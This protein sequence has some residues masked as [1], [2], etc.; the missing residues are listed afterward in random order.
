MST[1][2]PGLDDE[3]PRARTGSEN[4][5]QALA[6]GRY[7]RVHKLLLRMHPAKVAA[8]LEQAGREQR[9]AAWQQVD[10]AMEDR[11]LSHLRPALR[12]ELA[13]D[14]DDAPPL[15]PGEGAAPNQLESVCDALAAG[16]LKLWARSCV[17]PTPPRWLLMLDQASSEAPP[18]KFSRRTEAVPM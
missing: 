6:E 16:K 9:L 7:K 1:P 12:A 5:M 15:T 14:R 11:V 2:D 10:A 3:S 4:I 18:P 17:A 8:L 13:G